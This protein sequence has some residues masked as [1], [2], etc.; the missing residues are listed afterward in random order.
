MRVKELDASFIMPVTFR[1]PVR[2]KSPFRA[3]VPAYSL[4]ML[5]PLFAQTNAM[6]K[7]VTE[8]RELCGQVSCDNTIVE[9]SFELRIEFE[10]LIWVFA[11]A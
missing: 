8:G 9:N 6:V 4:E 1:F 3:L 2:V 10:T 7:S 5:S 11:N